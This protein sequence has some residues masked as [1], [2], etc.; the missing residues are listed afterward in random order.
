MKEYEK[1]L[2]LGE[3]YD[4][5]QRVDGFGFPIPRPAPVVTVS[6]ERKATMT[7]LTFVEPDTIARRV[8]VKQDWATA[9]EEVARIQ[10]RFRMK[11]AAE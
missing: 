5:G 2:T 8:E 10:A 3:L 9:E 6:A 11:D 7:P 4:D 1:Q